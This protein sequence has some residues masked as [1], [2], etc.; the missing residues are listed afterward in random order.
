MAL[1]NDSDIIAEVLVRLNQSST[2][3]FYTDTI[4]LGWF[5]N[6]LKWSHAYKK[7]PVTEYMDS[8]KNTT[9][10]DIG[11][12][13]YTY[14]TQL[15]SESIRWLRDSNSVLTKRI[16]QKI[17]YA[18]Y[19]QYQ[20]DFPTGQDLVFSDFGR[21]FYVN[22]NIASGTLYVFGQ[23]T[24]NVPSIIDSVASSL[25]STADDEANESIVEEMVSYGLQREKTPTSFYKGH[26]VSA[27]S[28]HHQTATSI[29]E[30]LWKRH[31]DEQFAYQ[32][33]NREMF[34]RFSVERGALRDDLLRRDQFY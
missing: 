10:P 20:N 24:P 11:T 18:D 23:T 17:T 26:Y 2:A 21:T 7:W 33:K 12:D 22:P 16:Y 13:G 5:Q 1:K 30:E 29:L 9:A 3:A 14:P 27:S 25:F 32:T 34:K 8:S 4:L 28:F 19:I 31:Q 6:A 15:R